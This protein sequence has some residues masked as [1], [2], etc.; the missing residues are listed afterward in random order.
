MGGGHRGLYVTGSLVQGEADAA[1]ERARLE[2][3][4]RA[5]V[6]KTLQELGYEETPA[7]RELRELR[8]A[9]A[10]GDDAW[11]EYT[12]RRDAE[13]AASETDAER[14]FDALKDALDTGGPAWDAWVAAN[15]GGG[16][17]AGG[18]PQP[19]GAGQTGTGP[20][21]GGGAASSDL[22]GLTVGT[23]SS[24]G[25]TTGTADHFD[26]TGKVTGAMTYTNLPAG[27][28]AV[29]IWTCDGAEVTRSQQAVSGDGWVSF[30]VMTDDA[31]GLAPGTWTLTITVEDTVLGRKTF[32]IGDAAG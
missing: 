5:Q 8:E 23:G 26:Q 7:G 22:G 29:G 4:W 21:G 16:Q 28:M 18:E 30:S 19:A 15:G 2:A 24:E 20:Q 32:T 25:A 14:Q 6:E 11:R 10:G 12:R 1:A 13:L 31:G 3:E 17:V 27:S 9:L